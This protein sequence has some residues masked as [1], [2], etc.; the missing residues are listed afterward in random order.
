MEK[1][2]NIRK[3]DGFLEPKY[4]RS[5][6]CLGPECP[7]DCCFGWQIDFTHDEVEKLKNA[8]CSEQLKG[9]INK[10][11]IPNGDIYKVNFDE[12]GRCPMFN[13]DGLCSIQLELGVDYM[14]K[15]CMVYPRNYFRI[16]NKILSYCDLSCYYI[17]DMLLNDSECMTLI[18]TS[19]ARYIPNLRGDTDDNIKKHHELKYREQL[20]MFFYTLIAGAPCSAE[21]A[22]VMGLPVAERLTELIEKRLYGR[23][24][25][26]IKAF[27]DQINEH[28]KTAN[29]CKPDYELKLK[30]MIDLYKK[31]MNST[32]AFDNIMTDGEIDLA[33]YEEGEKRFNEAFAG[34]PFAF[35]N[36]ALNMLM[37]LSIPFK[38]MD[39]SLYENYC[40]FA[41]VFSLLRTA[42]PA[43]Y[44]GE[45][46]PSFYEQQLKGLLPY[47]GRSILQNA[48]VVKIVIDMLKEY[49]CTDRSHIAALIK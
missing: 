27:W 17:I 29:E 23:I 4:F 25:D 32:K 48:G 44:M 49:G 40:Y 24:P 47:L 30:F 45:C 11:F 28:I 22:L 1:N 15:T 41:A 20:F 16:G 18:S 46:D 37:E 7:E 19:N 42:A 13:S 2:S 36:I 34:R 43:V 35:K 10:A 26:I 5:F 6:S 8:E 38:N 9:I 14:S 3:I 12:R 21:T 31:I 39:Y 33:K